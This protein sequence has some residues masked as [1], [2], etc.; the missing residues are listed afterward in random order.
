[1]RRG[2]ACLD[3]ALRRRR[4]RPKLRCLALFASDLFQQLCRRQEA[5]LQ[6]AILQ[7]A[8]F[9]EAIL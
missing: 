2:H 1:M 9:Q 4:M 6:E 7:E 8:I 5:I 3:D